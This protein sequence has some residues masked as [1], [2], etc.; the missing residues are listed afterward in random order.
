MDTPKRR[1][2]PPKNAQGSKKPKP[3]RTHTYTH[4]HTYSHTHTHTHSPEAIKGVMDAMGKL[5]KEK[6][7]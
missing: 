4:T 6:I 5:L 3:R 2:S 1:P 7:E